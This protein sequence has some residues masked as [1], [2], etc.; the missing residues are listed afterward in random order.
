MLPLLQSAV[1]IIAATP[2]CSA[3]RCH[4]SQWVAH[5]PASHVSNA[6]QCIVVTNRFL[7]AL[8]YAPTIELACLKGGFCQNS[9]NCCNSQAPLSP[10]QHGCIV[11]HLPLCTVLLLCVPCC[12]VSCL[13]ADV[14]NPRHKSES[15]RSRLSD[16]HPDAPL[17]VYVGRLGAEKNTEALTD[18]LQQVRGGSEGDRREEGRGQ[19]GEEG[20]GRQGGRS[21]STLALA[22]AFGH[23]HG[24]L[25]EVSCGL[26]WCLPVAVLPCNLQHAGAHTGVSVEANSGGESV[27]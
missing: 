5:S 13:A 8:P 25:S 15:M 11:Y 20:K 16:G 22:L 19:E 3:A 17:L 26:L 10:A 21:R 2:S 24:T 6:R 23:P 12:V 9:P 27:M 14:F 7:G 4:S 1:C 18:I